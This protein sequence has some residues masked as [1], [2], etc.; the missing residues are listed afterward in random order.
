M[1]PFS[2]N[3]FLVLVVLVFVALLLLFESGWLAWSA[4]YGAH[5]RRIQDR[6]ATAGSTRER[7]AQSRLMRERMLSDVPSV[8]RLLGRWAAMHAMDRYIRQSGLDWTVGK[9]LLSCAALAAVA[10]MLT[11]AQWGAGALPAL[12]ATLLAASAPLLFVKWRRQRRLQLLQ[13]QLPDALDLLTRALRAGHSFPSA[14]KMSG[15]ELPQPIAG[16]L[17]LVHDEVNFGTSLDGALTHLAERV[18]LTD[19]R[20]FVVAVLVQRDSGGNLTELLANLGQLVR[21]RLKLFARIRVLSS[22][23]RLSSWVLAVMP[24]GL[25][26]LMNI[27]NP[28]FMGVMW[29]DPI[30]VTITQYL[31]VLM[32]VGIVVL[33]KIVKIRV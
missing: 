10:W 17:R 14:L 6:L 31:L 18:P 5:A 23:G 26:A 33:V 29:T 30:G 12:A 1:I 28:E 32:A 15:E 9:L 25:A 20:Y 7:V 4:R 19:L 13:R 27:F 3:S 11:R 16:E 2:G 21:E 22:E 8:Q 24:F